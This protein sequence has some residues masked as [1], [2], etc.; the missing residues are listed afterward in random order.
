ML[1]KETATDYDEIRR[2][3][4]EMIISVEKITG[5]KIMVYDISGF[6][7]KHDLMNA[8]NFRLSRHGCEMC[9]YVMD[10]PGCRPQCVIHHHQ[11]HIYGNPD[12]IKDDPQWISCY[13]G[14]KEM[15]MPWQF[16]GK[17]IAY[18]FIGQMRIKGRD[19][20]YSDMLR[21]NGIDEGKL[22]EAYLK[23][24]EVQQE[25]VEYAA[26]LFSMSLRGIMDKI[27]EKNLMMYFMNRE[28]SLVMQ[29]FNYLMSHLEQG[30]NLK[31][32]SKDLYVSPAV[33]SR[34]FKQETG[35][36][37]NSYINARRFELACRLLTDRKQSI[38]AVSA[39]IGFKDVGTFLHWFSR[40]TDMTASEF[41]KLRMR[42]EGGKA[43]DPEAI[44]YTGRTM[45]TIR[46]KYMKPIRVSELAAQMHITPDHLAR[47]FKKET[48]KT[49][50][51]ELWRV[52]LEAAKEAL[53]Q[54]KATIAQ[55]ARQTGYPTESAFSQRFKE[56]T[57]ITPSEYRNRERKK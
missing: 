54:T 4:M 8:S 1:N 22:R 32:I 38:N 49:I 20:Y 17:L 26:K 18:F 28:S 19:L 16:R 31:D 51:E 9:E 40:Q 42:A 56:N 37:L 41:R 24:P 43:R 33:L 46:E 35:V 52:R 25:T 47:V 39:N 5:A 57:G 50:S 13:V 10:C 23:L 45:Q 48:G 44:D 30:M 14:Q 55:I 27:G 3:L 2:L 34:T 6:L 12:D 7:H 15:V 29:T 36:S 53:V 11:P 21:M